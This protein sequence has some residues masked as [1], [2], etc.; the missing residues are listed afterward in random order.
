[1]TLVISLSI[2]YRWIFTSCHSFVVVLGNIRRQRWQRRRTS[3][4]NTQASSS[5]THCRRIDETQTSHIQMSDLSLIYDTPTIPLQSDNTCTPSIHVDL[6]NSDSLI[7]SS[8]RN[9][10]P[11][12]SNLCLP[13]AYKDHLKTQT[14]LE[15]RSVQ[16]PPDYSKEPVDRGE[17]TDVSEILPP[18]Y[19]E[20][21][22]HRHWAIYSRGGL[23]YYITPIISR[24]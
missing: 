4:H 13:P 17:L 10:S 22:A 16:P 11:G 3:Q 8:N 1:M 7:E 19:E 18:T 15:F 14:E 24:E 9:F 12:S 6:A 20:S 23:Q 2:K 5:T 21:I